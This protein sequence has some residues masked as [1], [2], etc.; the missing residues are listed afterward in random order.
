MTAEEQQ[1]ESG[2]PKQQQLGPRSSE[3]QPATGRNAVQ[4][5]EHRVWITPG[6]KYERN[7]NHILE[8]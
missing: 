4:I 2:E 5:T 8:I 1:L 7:T 6:R 3:Q